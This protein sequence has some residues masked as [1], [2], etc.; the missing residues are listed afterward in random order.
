MPSALG[1]GL[2]PDPGPGAV[3]LDP[4][5]SSVPDSCSALAMFTCKTDAV[6]MEVG[7]LKELAH[8]RGE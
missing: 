7:S 1:G 8:M 6:Q 3:P 5:G 4:A 2:C